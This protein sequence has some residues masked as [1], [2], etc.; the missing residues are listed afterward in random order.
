MNRINNEQLKKECEMDFLVDDAIFFP[1]GYGRIVSRRKQPK[2][3]LVTK[4]VAND[5]WSAPH[6]GNIPVNAVLVT[7]PLPDVVEKALFPEKYCE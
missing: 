6:L 5:N 4:E 7:D 2:A 1:N 3:M